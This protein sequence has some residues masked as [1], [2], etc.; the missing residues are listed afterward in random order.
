VVLYAG[1]P[2]NETFA[3]L[4]RAFLQWYRTLLENWF[5]LS[6]RLLVT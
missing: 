3:V 2:E 6:A 1:V 5:Q 4:P